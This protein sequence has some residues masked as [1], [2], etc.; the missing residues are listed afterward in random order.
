MSYAAKVL[1]ATLRRLLVVQL[2]LVL[3]V[4]L[5]YAAIKGGESALAA[6]YGGGIA[7]INTAIM[8]WRVSR[9]N[10]KRALAE[11]YIGAS[12]RFGGTLL[13]MAIGMGVL[14]LDPLA[15]LLGFAAAQLGY[16]FNRVPM[17][18]PH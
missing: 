1:R 5:A 10:S 15:L 14:K 4:V 18:T 2:F 7:L 16:L 8:A 12:I 9:T 11:L 3:P 6:G 17:N 13:L